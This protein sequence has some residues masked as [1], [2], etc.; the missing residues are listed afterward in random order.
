MPRKTRDPERTQTE[1]LDKATFLLAKLGYAGCST[2]A[3]TRAAR[4]NK[5]MLYHYF[6][7][8]QGLY[9]AVL[10]RQWSELRKWFERI[11]MSN[12]DGSSDKS[13]ILFRILR[14]YS[15]FIAAN[16]D[17]VRLLMWEGLQGGKTSKSLW[18][19][20]RG[21]LFEDIRALLEATKREG[22]FA[23]ELDTGHLVISLMGAIN[24]YFAYSSTLGDLLDGQDPLAPAALKRRE[25]QIVALFERVLS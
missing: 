25:Q 23:R 4:V 8:K 6:G 22:R 17:F 3:I 9:R 15:E 7:N 21:P 13:H 11:P 1:I 24:F 5:R 18:K 19:E 2:D 12:L 16:P 10:V 20:V 14:T